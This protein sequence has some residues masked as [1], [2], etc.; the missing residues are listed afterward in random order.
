VTKEEALQYCLA[1]DI[2]KKS[3]RSDAEVYAI[4]FEALTEEEM[5]Q[6]ID[7]A[8]S[9]L[10]ERLGEALDAGGDPQMLWHIFREFIQ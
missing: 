3:G 8:W 1:F 2:L 10:K 9:I 6:V 7:M 4:L 5:I